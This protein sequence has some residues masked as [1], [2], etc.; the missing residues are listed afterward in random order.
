MSCREEDDPSPTGKVKRIYKTKARS[1]AG[2]VKL[3][4][5]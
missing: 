5:E 2:Q 1:A 4:L 3:E